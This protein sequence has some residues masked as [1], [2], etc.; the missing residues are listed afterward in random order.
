M[1]YRTVNIL[2]H[3]DLLRQILIKDCIQISKMI[4]IIRLPSL[5][6]HPTNK[7]ITFLGNNVYI[8]SA[9]VLHKHSLKLLSSRIPHLD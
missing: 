5:F 4:L 6:R 2:C 1:M 8:V 9:Q 3:C 7:D